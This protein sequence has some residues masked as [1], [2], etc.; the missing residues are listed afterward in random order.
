MILTVK[1]IVCH[2]YDLHH[3][4]QNIDKEFTSLSLLEL[5]L[6]VIQIIL[7]INLQERGSDSQSS[8]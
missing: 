5:K 1:C 6:S 2:N 7:T 3:K 8:Q 4:A